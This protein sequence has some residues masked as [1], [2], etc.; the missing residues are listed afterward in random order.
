MH[1]LCGMCAVRVLLLV[2]GGQ[3]RTTADNLP[4]Q[5]G[6]SSLHQCA[7]CGPGDRG[8]HFFNG[9]IPALNHRACAST[10]KLCSELSLLAE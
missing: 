1:V 4:V 3:T 9:G 2:F 10:N 6:A 8:R 5:P 7:L